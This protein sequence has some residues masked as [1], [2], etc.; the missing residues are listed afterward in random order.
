[1]QS[2]LPT[3][4]T[5]IFSVMTALANE[6]GAVNVSQGFPDYSVDPLLCEMLYE[7]TVRGNNQYAPMPGLP[8]LR[9]QVA[10]KYELV[11]NCSVDANSEVTITPGATAALYTAI[12]CLVG[13]GDEVIIM[14]PSYDS[15]APAVRA[16]GGVVRV[17]P[18]LP[19]SYLPDW[20]HIRSLV[21][22]RTR[23]IIVNSPHN[24]CGS[25]F[26]YDDVC[27]LATIA[28]EHNLMVISDEVYELITFDGAEHH[29]VLSHPDLRSRSFVVTSFGKTFHITGWKI[30]V[31]V[32][33]P[34]LTAVFR[35]VHQYL[36]F[37]VNTPAQVALARY[38]ED[39]SHYTGLSDFFLVKRD[40]VR[41]ALASSRW[42]L[43]PCSGSYFQLLGYENISDEHD[44]DFAK[45]ITREYGVATIPLSP[46]YQDQDCYTERV[47]RVCFAKTQETLSTA[48]DRLLL[49]R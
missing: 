22:Q 33:A 8:A 24:P 43:R 19:E 38:M 46:F 23:C 14:D 34:E 35:S 5:T 42:S 44:I 18:L 15:Y 7:A 32:A 36:S 12:A 49:V 2:K 48:L 25:A 1:M 40:H 20:D 41:N 26:T 37:C 21:T 45:R 28:N 3:V 47:V 27:A 16:N 11:H 39:S 10:R 4:E 30:G 29:S 31:C 6:V 13:P 17:S 9:D